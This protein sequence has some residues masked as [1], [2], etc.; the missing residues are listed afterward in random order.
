MITPTATP[1]GQGLH[2]R[3]DPAQRRETTK[4]KTAAPADHQLVSKNTGTTPI[5]ML[6]PFSDKPTI[7]VG[8][9]I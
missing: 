1:N 8:T 4:H 5:M 7:M 6:I 2:P 9:S 3:L